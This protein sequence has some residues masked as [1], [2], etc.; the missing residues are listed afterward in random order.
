MSFCLQRNQGRGSEQNRCFAKEITHRV[1][2]V[3]DLLW[4]AKNFFHHLQP[5]LDE[6]E[7]P[8]RLALANEPFPRRQAYVG[9]RQRATVA[10][11]LSQTAE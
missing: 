1:F 9:G 10:L 3:V 7:E 2:E 4:A 11:G 6:D 5:A 8:R